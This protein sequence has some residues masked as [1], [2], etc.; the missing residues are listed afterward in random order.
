MK[1][2]LPPSTPPVAASAAEH[3]K[4]HYDEN[5][6]SCST[7]GNFLSLICCIFLVVPGMLFPEDSFT[8]LFITQFLCQLSYTQHHITH[9]SD[10]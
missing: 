6:E 7:H 8:L 2:H 4:Q 9:H 10:F 5:D 3:N 1:Q